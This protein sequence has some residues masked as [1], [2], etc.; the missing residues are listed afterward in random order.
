MQNNKVSRLKAS[1]ANIILNKA[2]TRK[3]LMQK[4]IKI[5]SNSQNKEVIRRRKTMFKSFGYENITVDNF[6]EGYLKLGFSLLDPYTL[7]DIESSIS[8]V[9]KDFFLYFGENDVV[10]NAKKAVPRLTKIN[11]NI[12]TRIIKNSGHSPYWDDYED[13]KKYFIPDIQNIYQK[14]LRKKINNVK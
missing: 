4:I 1:F 3:S 14:W 10:I 5:I 13:F 12:K 6:P 7:W 11:P 2:M 9:K 8:K